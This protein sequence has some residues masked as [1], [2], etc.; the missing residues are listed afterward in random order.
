MYD[1]GCFHAELGLK[2][3]EE[4]HLVV[5][6]VKESLV[7]VSSLLGLNFGDD[8]LVHKVVPQIMHLH[9]ES[10]PWIFAVVSGFIDLQEGL[11]S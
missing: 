3:W 10:V 2:C 4:E 1:G 7:D 6:E 8:H 9:F 11:F 5:L